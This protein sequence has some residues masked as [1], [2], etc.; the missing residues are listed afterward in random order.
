M[1]VVFAALVVSVVAGSAG[2][3]EPATEPSAAVEDGAGERAATGDATP[4]AVDQE[5]SSAS[6][7]LR[8][9][10]DPETGAILSQPRPE[11][12]RALEALERQ[13]LASPAAA[14]ETRPVRLFAIPGGIGADLGGRFL[15]SMVV[16][17]R[18]DGSFETLC[19]DHPGE[20][21]GAHD[22]AGWDADAA[23][24]APPAGEEIR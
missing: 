23:E 6:G 8:V 5:A 21:H 13:R 17:V 9:F 3:Q 18:P 19:V 16:R 20:P 14:E 4:A 11:Q 15:S 7:G 2:A 10:L 24:T 22:E 1:L 12:L